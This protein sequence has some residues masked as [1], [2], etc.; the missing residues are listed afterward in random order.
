MKQL[1][2]LEIRFSNGWSLTDSVINILAEIDSLEELLLGGFNADEHFIKTLNDFTN[3]KMCKLLTF[4]TI[5]EAIM[6]HARNFVISTDEK[7]T[8]FGYRCSLVR[9]N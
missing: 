1:K 7:A 9:K 3:L 4:N 8:K 2:I 6:A 5:P